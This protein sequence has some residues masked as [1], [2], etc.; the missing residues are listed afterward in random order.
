MKKVKIV[1][2]IA[3]IAVFSVFFN[4]CGLFK[5]PIEEAATK[6]CCDD[7]EPPVGDPPPGN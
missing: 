1:L 4:S 2:S 7:D 6:N 3:T 5:D